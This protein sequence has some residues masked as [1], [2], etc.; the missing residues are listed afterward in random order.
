MKKKQVDER[1]I[2]VIIDSRTKIYVR[3]GEEAGAK[4]RWLEK[5]KNY[6]KTKRQNS[7]RKKQ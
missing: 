2:E 7:G 5:S 4:E 6:G 1:T 3:P